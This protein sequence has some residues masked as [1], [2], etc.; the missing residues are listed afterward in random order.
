[1]IVLKLRASV[2]CVAQAHHLSINTHLRRM[3]KTLLH[4]VRHA[5]LARNIVLEA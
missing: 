4:R 3:K 2:L 1:M 5:R